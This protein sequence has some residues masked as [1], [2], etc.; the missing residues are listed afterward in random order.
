MYRSRRIEW[1]HEQRVTRRECRVRQGRHGLLRR[2]APGLRSVR[3]GLPGRDGA[4]R[5]RGRLSRRSGPARGQGAE[6]AGDGALC[7]RE[8]AAH[9]APA[10]SRLLAAHP[11]RPARGRDHARRGAAQAAARQAPEPRA[12]VSRQGLR[13]AAGG[14][15]RPHQESFALQDRIV[16]L[17]NAISSPPRARARRSFRSTRWDSRWRCCSARSAATADRQCAGAPR[18]GAGG[19]EGRSASRGRR[20]GRG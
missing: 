19:C 10:R 2:P 3:S 9:H 18:S 4:R 8:H 11:P 16:Q 7:N 1:C 17:D 15:A 6:V 14:P 12:P 5:A 13:G 20:A